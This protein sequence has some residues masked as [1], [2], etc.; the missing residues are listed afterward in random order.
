MN[1]ISEGV[2]ISSAITPTAGAAGTSDINGT[3][4]D[5]QGVD[6]GLMVVRMG[7][8]TS[9]AVT[10]IKAQQGAASDLSDAADLEGTGQTFADTDDENV[11]YIDLFRPSERYVRLVVDRGTADAVVADALYYQYKS[12]ELPVTQGS[13]I[14]GESHITPDEGTA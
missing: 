4:L 10:S 7:A 1:V 12:S 13:D 2:K 9:S 3:T 8:I 5:M 14:S 6:G 11:F